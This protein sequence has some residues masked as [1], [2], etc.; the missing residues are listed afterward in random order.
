MN[1]R[2]LKRD[3]SWKY[4]FALLSSKIY[5]IQRYV[6]HLDMFWCEFICLC[7]LA[8]MCIQTSEHGPLQVDLIADLMPPNE[9]TYR[10]NNNNQDSKSIKNKFK[11]E[12]SVQ[13]Q[14]VINV[15]KELR[16]T[17]RAK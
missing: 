5:D 11:C 12:K 13:L 7:R 9:K 10:H 6:L 2:Q 4:S 1:G 14:I 3:C 15:K 17:L 8:H 16:K